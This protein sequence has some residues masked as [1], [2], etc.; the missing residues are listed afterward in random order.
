MTVN[1]YLNKYNNLF[2]SSV[3]FAPR[4]ICEDGFSMYVQG[5]TR[6]YCRPHSNEGP[7]TH[8]QVAFCS[9]SVE[10][11]Y[12]FVEVFDYG[13]DDDETI[14][15]QNTQTIYGFVPVEVVDQLIQSHGGIKQ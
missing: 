15:E 2:S 5:N 14:P 4:L 1:E 7:W 6:D 9:S 12:P 13:E 10:Q 8:V 11:I 3:A